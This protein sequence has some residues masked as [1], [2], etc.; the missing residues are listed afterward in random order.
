MVTFNR[1][2]N[3]NSITLLLNSELQQ[4]QNGIADNGIA[5]KMMKKTRKSEVGRRSGSPVVT[6]VGLMSKHMVS[7][8][9]SMSTPFLVGWNCHCRGRLA[10]GKKIE[11]DRDKCH[12]EVGECYS[13]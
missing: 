3:N 6:V 4:Q 9:A 13:T 7:L 1:H 8:F 2:L 10:H 5:K 12:H 11:M